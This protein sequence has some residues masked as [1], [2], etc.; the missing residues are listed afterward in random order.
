MSIATEKNHFWRLSRKEDINLV[1]VLRYQPASVYNE[2]NFT[3]SFNLYVAE[4]GP[5]FSEQ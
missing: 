2:V 3:S 4:R 5:T 1:L